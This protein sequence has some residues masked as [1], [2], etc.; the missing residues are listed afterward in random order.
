MPEMHST[1]IAHVALQDLLDSW[2]KYL[3]E[4]Y[5]KRTNYQFQID[6]SLSEIIL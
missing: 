4:E 6:I 1:D 2:A 3:Y 5:I